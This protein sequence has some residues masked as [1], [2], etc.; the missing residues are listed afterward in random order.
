MLHAGDFEFVAQGVEVVRQLSLRQE[1]GKTHGWHGAPR[2][3]RTCT[4]TDTNSFIRLHSSQL[5]VALHQLIPISCFYHTIFIPSSF[6]S[7]ILLSQAHA[8]NIYRQPTIL[9]VVKTAS[10]KKNEHTQYLVNNV[11]PFPP[12]NRRW[13]SS[14]ID[15]RPLGGLNCSVSSHFCI[16][17]GAIFQYLLPF[18]WYKIL[19]T[20][21]KISRGRQP[22]SSPAVNGSKG[23][24]AHPSLPYKVGVKVATVTV[25]AC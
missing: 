5:C 9:T 22:L 2:A 16:S 11:F 24:K 1:L 20:Q 7:S 21:V 12:L 18:P 3:V 25:A 8:F 15:C 14:I 4:H 17:L 19:A 23:E 6:A 10:K 13:L